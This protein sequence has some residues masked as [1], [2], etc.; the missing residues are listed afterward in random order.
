MGKTKPTKPRQYRSRQGRSDK[1]Y[2][3]N[4]K[5]MFITLCGL[6]AMFIYII[7]NSIISNG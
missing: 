4:M 6:G 3:S 5:V 7:I 1:Q 2:S